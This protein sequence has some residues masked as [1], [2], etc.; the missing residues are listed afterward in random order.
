MSLAAP[1]VQVRIATADDEAEVR[2]CVM[3]AYQ[4]YV[5]DIGREPAPMLADYA[6]LID[7]G[8]V[9]VAVDRAALL[10]VIVMWAEPD[11]LYVDNVAVMPEAQGRGIGSL[12]LDVALDEAR[13]TGRQEIRLYTNELMTA[14]LTYYPRHGYRETHRAQAEGYRRVYFS[15][16][17]DR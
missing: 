10:G 16:S 14:N 4:R 7:D 3:S 17:V 15:R 6:A 1:D 5:A 13:R 11:H 12:L 2:R 9:R 8:R